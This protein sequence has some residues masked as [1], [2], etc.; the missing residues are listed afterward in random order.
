MLI[1]AK[2][3]AKMHCAK[4]AITNPFVTNETQLGLHT[5][6]TRPFHSPYVVQCSVVLRQLYNLAISFISFKPLNHDLLTEG[7]HFCISFF[8]MVILRKKAIVP[9][10]NDNYKFNRSD[11][12]VN[13]KLIVL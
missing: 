1:H 11:L 8:S 5:F 3:T 10:E 6:R 2:V 4:L 13:I 12:Q 7:R 9:K